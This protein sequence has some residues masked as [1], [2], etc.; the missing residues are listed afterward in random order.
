MAKVYE[1]YVI[2]KISKLVKDNCDPATVI[3][4]EISET[5]V[6]AVESLIGDS[7]FVVELEQK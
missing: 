5:I 6:E 3:T 1:E 4:D 7:S 2:V